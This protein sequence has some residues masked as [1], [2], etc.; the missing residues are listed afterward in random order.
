MFSGAENLYSYADRNGL[1]DG[2]NHMKKLFVACIVVA[3]FCGAPALAA[4]MPV[5]APPPAPPPAYSWTGFYVGGNAG[6]V[7]ENAS[8][9]SNF[10]DLSTPGQT[11]S[12]TNPQGNSFSDTSFVGG[13]QA[14]YNWQLNPLWMVGLE[15]DWDWTHA[16]HSFCRQT[17]QLA[18]ACSDNFEGFES[19]GS[20]T[21]WIATARGR[22]GVIV[23]N[24]LLYG[25]GGVA[26]GR[27]DTTLSLSCLVDGC[28]N[29]TTKLFT[30]QTSDT[31]KVGWVAGL[32]AEYAI[33][34]NW[35]AKAEWLYI[36]LGTIS[37]SLTVIGSE[38]PQAMTWSRS[39]IYNEFR[40]GV[41]YRFH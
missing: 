15:A 10:L 3:A 22:A 31:T 26:W 41:N 36:D 35:S 19:I 11:G 16:S 38:G 6:A 21:D 14:G 32:G 27:V 30:S 4:D 34:A 25:T 9:T 8:G 29:S 23:G 17:D 28:G 37:N 5:K 1:A 12:L 33:G 7:I 40:L 13:V 2:G 18:L 24:F 20:T 39:E